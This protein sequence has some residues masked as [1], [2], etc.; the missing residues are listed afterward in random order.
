M[1]SFQGIRNE[2]NRATAPLQ[3]AVRRPIPVHIRVRGLGLADT[4]QRANS[5][6]QPGIT[7]PAQEMLTKLAIIILGPEQKAEPL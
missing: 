3:K 7:A 2:E 6:Q 1:Y 5:Q 4:H